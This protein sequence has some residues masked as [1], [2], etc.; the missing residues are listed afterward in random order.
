MGL[1]QDKRE[2]GPRE[3]IGI[4]WVVLLIHEVVVRASTSGFSDVLL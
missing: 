1:G 2:K 3:L 4:G